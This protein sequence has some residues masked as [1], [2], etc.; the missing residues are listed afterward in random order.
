MDNF[1]K[2]YILVYKNYKK[3]QRDKNA[4]EEKMEK[5]CDNYNTEECICNY[6]VFLLRPYVCEFLSAISPFF[7][8]LVFSNMHY[9][10][11]E[12][13]VCHIEELLNKPI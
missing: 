9:K 2:D 8:I 4:E 6:E 1:K 7:E 12:K 10:I 5:C 3:K 13:I 11:L